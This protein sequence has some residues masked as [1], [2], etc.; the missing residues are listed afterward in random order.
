M[1]RIK[2][3]LPGTFTFSTVITVRISDIN[4]GGHVGNDSIMALI[5]E[6]RIRFFNHHGF[7]EL[8]MAGVGTIM[9]DAAIEFKAELFYGE[10]IKASVVAE[11]FS[12][13]S[14]EL[15]YKLEKKQADG[16]LIPVVYAKTGITC[17]DYSR[18]KVAALPA[19]VAEKFKSA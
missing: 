17:F 9:T 7:T 4:Y 10:E 14:F 16:K 11:E 15:Y 1:A 6:A 3:E 19:E 13:I 2:I 8:D 18:K 12:N 5:H